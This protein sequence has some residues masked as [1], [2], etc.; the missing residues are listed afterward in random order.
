MRIIFNLIN[1]G[2]GD[3]GGSQT[4]VKSANILQSLGHEVIIIDSMD[5]KY[6][7]DKLEVPH[8][9]IKNLKDVP[10]ADVVIATGYK[11]VRS[12]LDLSDRCGIK[13]HWIRGWETWKIPENKIVEKI[14]KVPTIKFVNG[15]RLYNKLK[16]F[17]IDSTI[18]RPG[19]DIDLYYKL[20]GNVKKQFVIGG[21]YNTRHKSK[22][23]QMVLDLV[24]KLQ[25]SSVS[26]DRKSVV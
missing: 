8:L 23:T 5:V 17:N 20:D 12:T 15:K 10:I 24:K 9:I 21:L 26:Q 16:S 22:N 25:F 7:W 13:C 4:L 14:L 2:L 6:T 1:C 11:T 18:I 3:N 19:V